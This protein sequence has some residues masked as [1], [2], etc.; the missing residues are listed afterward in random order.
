MGNEAFRDLI[1]IENE[2][3]GVSVVVPG[4]SWRPALSLL[5]AEFYHG[6]PLQ[7]S[8]LRPWGRQNHLDPKGRSP[9]IGNDCWD[10]PS[11]GIPREYPR[12]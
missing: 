10:A 1:V 7:V 5:E 4:K 6:R 8:G 3:F 9:E 11:R 12:G 2:T